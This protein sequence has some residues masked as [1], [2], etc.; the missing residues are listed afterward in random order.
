VSNP[1]LDPSHDPSPYQ[2]PKARIPDK[3][4]TPEEP[5]GG[6]FKKLLMVLGA[7]FALLI[8]VFVVGFGYLAYTGR[9]L[10]EEG[11]RYVDEAVPLI[12]TDWDQQAL[13]T[14]ISSEFKAVLKPGDLEGWF[15]VY[16]KLGKLKR[17]VGSRGDANVSV[18]TQQGKVITG[19][20]LVQAEFETGPA[21][22]AVTLVK[23]E[24]QWQIMGF[25]VKADVL[26]KP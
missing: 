18:T 15:T 6:G 24:G 9:G 3:W 17:Y 16:R 11:K 13:Q 8:V 7:L 21:E 22:I 19:R 1:R 10:D 25:R 20:Y 23:R 14:R 5:R 26:M 2:A 4:M 12:V